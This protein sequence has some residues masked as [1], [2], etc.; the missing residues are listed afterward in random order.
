[1]NN[2]NQNSNLQSATVTKKDKEGKIIFSQTK[3]AENLKEFNLDS[4]IMESLKKLPEQSLKDASRKGSKEIYIYSEDCILDSDRKTF[5]R[6]LREAKFQYASN[7]NTTCRNSAFSNKEKVECIKF[8]LKFYKE[9]FRTNNFELN[10]FTDTKEI[11][12]RKIAQTCFDVCK[13]YLKQF[14]N[15]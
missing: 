11:G 9:N 6:K 3:L 7:V 8:F 1:M 14:P 5:R 4:A 2:Q 12:K 15:S 10:S 13:D